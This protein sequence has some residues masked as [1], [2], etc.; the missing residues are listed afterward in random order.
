MDM[1]RSE[2]RSAIEWWSIS[3]AVSAAI[4]NIL[5]SVLMNYQMYMVDLY[6]QQESIVMNDPSRGPVTDHSHIFFQ[7]FFLA[8]MVVV[9]IFRRHPAFT[10]PYASI[11]FLIL[12]GRLY[13][14]VEFYRVGLDAVSKFDPP[15]LLWTIL[16][17]IS[18]VIVAICVMVYL[19]NFIL[20]NGADPHGEARA[21]NS[22]GNWTQK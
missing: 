16:A 18:F 10:L 1:T 13:Y 22:L 19:A 9:A 14:L 15:Q 5:S 21:P 12:A 11:L 20:E 3:A 7:F 2:S 4:F 6:V 8:P 17:T